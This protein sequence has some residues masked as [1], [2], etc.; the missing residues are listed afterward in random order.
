M[1]FARI[2][3]ASADDA[4]Q[5]GRVLEH[6]WNTEESVGSRGPFTELMTIAD[7]GVERSVATIDFAPV[8]RPTFWKSMMNTADVFP[9]LHGGS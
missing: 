8:K 7:I 4:A 2:R 1:V 6:R 9:F 3:A 5:I